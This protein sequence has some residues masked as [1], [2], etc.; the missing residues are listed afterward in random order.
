VFEGV[1]SGTGLDDEI[2]STLAD[3]QMSSATLVEQL[4]DLGGVV[5]FCGR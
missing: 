3:A 5:G 4:L 2:R 1:S